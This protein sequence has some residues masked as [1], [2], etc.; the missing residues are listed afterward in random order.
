MSKLYGYF[1]ENGL[2]TR[3]RIFVVAGVML[4]PPVDSIRAQLDTLEQDT[5]KGKTKWSASKHPARMA[6]IRSIFSNTMLQ[7]HLCYV[8]FR[9]TQDYDA[10]M[11]S[12]I[13]RIVTS[14]AMPDD[15]INIYVDALS[16]TKRQMYKKE[17]KR[18]GLLMHQL[19]GVA[20][21]ENDAVIRLV[22][23]LAGFIRDAVD[24]PEGEIG[25]LWS[26]ACQ[27]RIVV[28]A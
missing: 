4:Q 1:D 15:V 28:E 13:E 12:A 3:G 2:E 17:L 9:N 10:A 20:K 26:Q 6:Y 7:G 27:K 18:L 16:K 23:A 5:G 19:R 22:D 8:V 25:R 11:I 21:D 14:Y 24:M